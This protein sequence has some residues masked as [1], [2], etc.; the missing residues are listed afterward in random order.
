MPPTVAAVEAIRTKAA[1]LGFAAVGITSASLPEEHGEHLR[2]F[3][4]EGRH[5]SMEWLARRVDQRCEPRALWAEAR[6]VICVGLPYAPPT[7]E[8]DPGCG[9]IAAYACGRDYHDVLKGKLKHL[10]QFLVAR[11]GGAVKVFVDT[12]PVLEKPL[13]EQAGLGWIGRH[14]NLVS[15]RHG[16]WLLLGEIFTTL[17][18]PPD[19]PQTNHCGRCD[20]CRAAC[21]TGAL[22]EPYRLEP[23]RCLAYLTIEH[24]GPIPLPLRPALGNRIFGCDIC[25]AAC[26]WNRFARASGEMALAARP[27]LGAFPL[28]EL[29]ALDAAGFAARFAGTP[30]RRLGRQRLLRNVMIAIGNSG[31]REL[32]AAAASS[33]ADGDPVLAEAAGWALARLTG[34]A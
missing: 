20:R 18:L 8:A 9:V 12:A 30:V 15:R 17:E 22:A 7:A 3:C 26:P 4:A 2:R 25:L 21:P 33:V 24:R 10:A 32:A 11:L 13:A 16:N 19:P 27:V 31:H 5:G 23:R 6:S 14:G 28:A 34:A 29:A 1:S